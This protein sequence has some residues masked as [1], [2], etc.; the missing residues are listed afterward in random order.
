M[1]RVVAGPVRRSVSVELV[2]AAALT[3]VECTG[4]DR[5]GLWFADDLDEATAAAVAEWM[6]SRDDAELARRAAL[7]AVEPSALNAWEIV[8]A[9]VLGDPL[10]EPVYPEPDPIPEPEP[11]AEP[12]PSPEPDPDPTVTVGTSLTI[13]TPTSN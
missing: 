10:P 5:A 6:A 12:L 4:I 1:S 2:N 8:R 11:P 7:R 3:Q 13:T 9:F